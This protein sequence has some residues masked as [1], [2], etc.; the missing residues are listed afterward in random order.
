[1]EF[2]RL[3]VAS[4]IRPALLWIVFAPVVLVRRPSRN[5]LRDVVAFFPDIVRLLWAL[6]RDRTSR[7]AHVGG[8]LSRS[9]IAR[10]RSTSSPISSP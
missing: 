5:T 1:M 8:W 10:S 9:S 4:L 7:A 6:A 3:F 2:V